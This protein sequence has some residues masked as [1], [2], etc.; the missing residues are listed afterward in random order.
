MMVFV[1]TS[2][3]SYDR[4]R[5]YRL[6]CLASLVVVAIG[7]SRPAS[8]TETPGEESS[9]LSAMH[10][11]MRSGD[12][13][14]AGELSGEVLIAYPDDPEIIAQVALVAHNNQQP[15]MA[16]DLLVDAARTRTLADQAAVHR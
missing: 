9:P 14:T 16:A 5:S 1:D 6:I 8:Q 4:G 11:T 12:W 13:K 3:R 2:C 15:E 10:A 7:C